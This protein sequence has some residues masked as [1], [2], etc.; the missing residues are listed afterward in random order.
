MQKKPR[1]QDYTLVHSVHSNRKFTWWWNC[2]K[3]CNSI[4]MT[5]QQKY[6]LSSTVPYPE[7]DNTNQLLHMCM[8]RRERNYPTFKSNNGHAHHHHILFTTS[9]VS[10][11]TTTTAV[12]CSKSFSLL[13]GQQQNVTQEDIW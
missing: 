10:A 11:T 7:I 3:R 1:A 2:C 4:P 8:I 13:T 12:C 5:F 6:A 9:H